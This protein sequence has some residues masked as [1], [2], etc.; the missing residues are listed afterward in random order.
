MKIWRPR[1]LRQLGA[2]AAVGVGQTAAADSE[3]ARGTLLQV[4]QGNAA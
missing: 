3:S 1:K 2:V 4:W